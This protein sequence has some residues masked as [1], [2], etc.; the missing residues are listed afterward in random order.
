M[1]GTH[2]MSTITATPAVKS[3]RLFA[4]IEKTR[5]TFI[6]ELWLPKVLSSS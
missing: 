3:T 5:V 1:A 4:P 6:T 2:Q